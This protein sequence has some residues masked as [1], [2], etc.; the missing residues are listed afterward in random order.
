MLLP[1]L[2]I[3]VIMATLAKNPQ[4]RRLAIGWTVVVACVCIWA[5]LKML[6]YIPLLDQYEA[7]RSAAVEQNPGLVT[8]EIGKLRMTADL[9]KQHNAETMAVCSNATLMII[10]STWLGLFLSRIPERR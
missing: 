3:P 2:A 6:Q 5:N 1:G 9:V 4:H 8:A 7:Q 10:V